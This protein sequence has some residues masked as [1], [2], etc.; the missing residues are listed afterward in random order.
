MVR[1]A[2]LL[3][4][5]LVAVLALAPASSASPLLTALDDPHAIHSTQGPSIALARMR[6]AGTS[7]VRVELFWRQ[8]APAVRPL[9]FDPANPADPAY[10]FGTYDG[11]VRVAKARGLQILLVINGAPDWAQ[12]VG[13]G[14]AGTV[15][16]NPNELGQFARAAAERYDGDFVPVGWSA[17]L[18]EVRYWEIWNE[19]NL[20]GFLSPQ[21][22]ALGNSVAPEHYRNMVNAAASG[23]HAA[24]PRNMVGAGALAPFGTPDGHSPMDFTRKVLCMSGGPSPAPTCNIRVEFD[25]WSHHPYTSGGPNHHAFSADDVSIGDLPE[26]RRLVRAA[27]RAGHVASTKRVTFWVT[28]FSWDTKGPDAG[29]V[30]HRRHARWTAEALY[31]MW[32]SGVTLVTWWLLRDRPYP[33]QMNQSGFYYCGRPTTKDDSTCENLPLTADVRKLSFR[34]FRF[35]FVAFPRNGRLFVWGRTPF[36]RSGRVAI[37]VRTSGGW[38][39]LATV[40][41][42][43]DGIFGRTLG[44]SAA[45]RPVRARLVGKGDSSV[46]FVAKRTVDVPLTFPFGCGGGAPC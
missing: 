11:L 5:V 29:G 32:S 19:P 16:P 6:A 21:R 7:L 23:I 44:V 3:A 28:E 9:L 13:V 30:P 27:V 34:A 36:G 8:V 22:D 10:N 33:A 12:G 38:R 26:L 17:P 35:P 24:D 14:R 18:P 2:A 31:R 25:A 40:A 4:G 41:A 20:L 1:F 43:R 42:N 45:N 37:E 46:P 39:R 15:A